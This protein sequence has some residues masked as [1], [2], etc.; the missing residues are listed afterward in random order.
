M[1]VTHD[2]ECLVTQPVK[3][4]R[5]TCHSH[6]L[7][8]IYRSTCTQQNLRSAWH[9]ITDLQSFT[10]WFPYMIT[11]LQ[12]LALARLQICNISLQYIRFTH[13]ELWFHHSVYGKIYILQFTVI[14]KLPTLV[15]NFCQ[16]RHVFFTYHPS[17]MHVSLYRKLLL[18][19]ILAIGLNVWQDSEN[20]ASNLNVFV[21]IW[22][23]GHLEDSN[24]LHR[25][26]LQARFCFQ[27]Y[28][29]W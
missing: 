27:R 26:G 28:S 9:Y 23:E 19:I 2:C 22:N 4:V 18:D 7:L 8:D 12:Y 24:K 11:D 21:D 13:S 29:F 6:N 25:H 5:C 1:F 3:S 16:L 15:C 17:Y 20:C 14:V 10:N